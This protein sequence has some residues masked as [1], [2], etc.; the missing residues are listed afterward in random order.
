MNEVLLT[1]V[2][3]H[4]DIKETLLNLINTQFSETDK[5]ESDSV[6]RLDWTQSEDFDREWVKYFMPHFKTTY[7][8][9]VNELGYN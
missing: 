2:E 1:R 3:S 5:N 4:N 6:T 7:Q 8:Q 9:L